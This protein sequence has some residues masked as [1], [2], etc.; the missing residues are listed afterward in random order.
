MPAR[1][2]PTRVLT[3]P[4]DEADTPHTAGSA[5]QS[6]PAEIFE[7]RLDPSAV[8]ALLRH[9]AIA[10]RREGRA[11]SSSVTLLWHDAADGRLAEAGVLVVLE[12]RGRSRVER[13]ERILPGSADRLDPARP[14]PVLAEAPSVGPVGP[15]VLDQ[16]A[17]AGIDPAPLSALAAAVG[18]RTEI[19]LGGP[20]P[21]TLT[22]HAGHLRTLAAERPFARV[23][24]SAPASAR[25]EVATL[26]RALTE[27]VPLAVPHVSLG[28]EARALA[29]GLP[30]RPLRR[31]APDLAAAETVEE[32]AIRA[33]GHL[34][35]ALA[36]AGPVAAEGKDPEGVHQS[37]VAIRRLR[38]VITVFKAAI[39]CPVM[40]ELKA[41]AGEIA[42]TL[43]PARD[44]DVFL[45]ET[46]PPVREAFAER[47]EILGLG[48]A[49]L[50]ARAQA[51]RA[52]RALLEG[53]GFRLFLLDVALAL[54]ERPWRNLAEEGEAAEARA[55]LLDGPLGAFAVAA[56]DKRYKRIRRDGEGFAALDIPALH[57]LRIDAKRLRYAG[58]LFAPLYPEK[59]VRRFLKSLAALQDALGHLN[60]GAVAGALLEAVTAK[61]TARA[62]AIGI[63]EGWVARGAATAREDAAEAWEEFLDREPFWRD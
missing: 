46:F 7:F 1:P 4:S 23:R 24:L 36:G 34:A 25:A 5:S 58:E 35:L 8:P 16:A 39:A 52:V 47:R 43:G 49:A 19:R 15:A 44:W 6:E 42:R 17:L 41:R 38:S 56:L 9:P 62:R 30:A 53:P 45:T 51:Y 31:G 14:L 29:L 59:K 63:V 32:G 10:R 40:D 27:T 33:I 54:A 20:T 2:A 61:E 12:T 18:K 22:L 11:R 60:D 3:T 28:E 50:E 21:L 13:L 37:R 26:L 48:K 57:A 55:A